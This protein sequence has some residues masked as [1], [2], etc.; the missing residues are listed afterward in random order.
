MDDR[1]TGGFDNFPRRDE[2]E[3]YVRKY[4]TT[5]ELQRSAAVIDE[6]VAGHLSNPK[7]NLSVWQVLHA[8]WRWLAFGTSGG[9]SIAL[10]V[11]FLLALPSGEVRLHVLRSEIRNASLPPVLKLDFKKRSIWMSGS[12]VT[13]QGAIDPTFPAFEAAVPIL[14][15]SPD[16]TASFQ[17]TLQ[18]TN[19]INTTSKVIGAYLQGLLKVQDV[20][21]NDVAASFSN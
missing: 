3:A 13:L 1:S 18:L 11:F 8:H 20:G 5:H 10:L 2:V 19:D 4:L 15:K 9:L 7:A 16:G 17:G 12:G 14:L 6:L 21:T